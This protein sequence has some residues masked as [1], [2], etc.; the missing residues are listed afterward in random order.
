M[1]K[2]NDFVATLTIE[3]AEET[4]KAI[5]KHVAALKK[6]TPIKEESV[7][8][9][10]A[11]KIVEE[12]VTPVKAKGKKIETPSAPV[13][14]KKVA[15]LASGEE[16][17]KS[18]AKS[19]AK[20]TDVTRKIT[21]P[22]N[23]SHTKILKDAFGDDKKAFET[24]KK[25]VNKY[26]SSLSDDDADAKNHDE[27]VRDWLKLKNETKAEEP[28]TFDILTIEDLV[29]MK[30]L[31]E[32]DKV[33]I[34]WHPETGRHVTG[35]DADPEEGMDEAT[36]DGNEYLVAETTKRVYNADEEFLGFAGIGKFKDIKIVE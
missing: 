19:T 1:S 22:A 26:Y 8:N 30:D 21:F 28:I 2:I 18:V 6:G 11:G 12:P 5:T 33:G 4:R 32:T 9:A 14:G 17:T 16:E 34:Y 36:M 29:S 35:P 27:H 20:N 23:G 24:A 25:A 31:N 3:M 7:A 10:G 13:K 15:K